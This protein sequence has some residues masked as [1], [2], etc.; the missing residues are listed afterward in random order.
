MRF[1]RGEHV[2]TKTVD[3]DKDGIEGIVDMGIR[4]GKS[5]CYQDDVESQ[6]MECIPCVSVLPRSKL[7]QKPSLV[8]KPLLN[9][10]TKRWNGCEL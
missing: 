8:V 5:S 6:R 1:E 3:D 7:G 9:S 2:D 10:A 4:D